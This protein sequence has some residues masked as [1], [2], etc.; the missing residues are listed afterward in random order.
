MR[1]TGIVSDRRLLAH[2]T[3]VRH[4]ES[5]ERLA[6]LCE[7]FEGAEYEQF[8]RVAPRV[9]TEEELRRVHGHAHVAAVAESAGRR[10]TQFDADTPASSG[11]FEAARLAAGGAVAMA[12]AILDGEIDNGFAALRPPGHHAEAT[13]PMGFCLF[14][15]VAIVARHLLEARG[16]R[17]VLIVDWDVH[18]G[19][20]TQHSFYDSRDVLY[21]STHQY[22][23]YPGTGAPNEI[24]SGEG[25]GYTL[26]VPMPAGAGSGEFVAA[27]RELVVPVATEFAPEFVLVSAGFDAH[28]DDPLASLTL[29]TPAYGALT[30]ALAGVADQT[31]GG[32][33]MLLL[34]GG[35]DLEALVDSVRTS[36][37]HLREPSRFDADRGGELTSWGEV[38]RQALAPFWETI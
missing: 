14:N 21:V 24:G 13:R 26:N 10:H 30:D 2:E 36:V 11:S 16:L 5:P 29:D 27:F 34:E 23:F 35:Y 9:A 32:R 22:P 18:H 19:N 4:P 33:L 28:R 6:V 7:L 12:D 3:G 37:A 38:S 31:A 1:R 20:G 17:R 25:A 15:N 8:V